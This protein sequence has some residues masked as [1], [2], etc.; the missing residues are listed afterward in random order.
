MFCEVRIQVRQEADAKRFPVLLSNGNKVAGGP[1]DWSPEKHYAIFD[2]PHPKPTHYFGV[3][4]GNFGSL[5]DTFVTQV[6]LCCFIYSAPGRH[7]SCRCMHIPGD[8]R[9]AFN[10]TGVENFVDGLG[11]KR[12]LLIHECKVCTSCRV[13]A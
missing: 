7:H 12:L 6:S 13:G 10:T 2:D 5:T 1:L 11:K 9:E 3:V 8:L 4:A